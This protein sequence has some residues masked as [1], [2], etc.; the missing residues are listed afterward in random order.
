M[1]TDMF[2]LTQSQS[3]SFLIHDRFN[4]A[5]VARWVPNEEMELL[6]LPKLWALQITNTRLKQSLKILKG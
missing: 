6:S 5:R 4:V 2:N 3:G 1:T